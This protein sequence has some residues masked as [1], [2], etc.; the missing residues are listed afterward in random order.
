[1][2]WLDAKYACYTRVNR[3][4]SENVIFITFGGDYDGTRT[5]RFKFS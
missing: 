2:V 5:T 1:M 3:E 4:N